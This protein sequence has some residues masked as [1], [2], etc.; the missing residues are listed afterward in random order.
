VGLA[1][2]K[3][4]LPCS[5]NSAGCRCRLSLLS[6]R[7]Q[8][9]SITN[10]KTTQL[11][12]IAITYIH[13]VDSAFS[14]PICFSAQPSS[15][16]YL[17]LL[18]IGGTRRAQNLGKPAAAFRPDSFVDLLLDISLPRRHIGKR[19][20]HA[21]TLQTSRNAIQITS[22]PDCSTCLCTRPSIP[23]STKESSTAS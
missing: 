22:R 18:S 3:W 10:K 16:G 6:L 7:A 1:H 9:F 23:S 8:Q 15:H 20:K 14:A 21:S 4:V 12:N 2:L 5:H 13:S 17:A 11:L 19:A